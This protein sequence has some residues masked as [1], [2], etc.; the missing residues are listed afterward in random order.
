MNTLNTTDLRSKSS[1]KMHRMNRRDRITH[2]SQ[3]CYTHR[4]KKKTKQTK[5]EYHTKQSW[6][7]AAY[8][9]DLTNQLMGIAVKS[10]L[11]RY[12]NGT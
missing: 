3:K 12:Q 6:S 11:E 1:L 10:T 8:T 9:I 4:R 5:K 7:R 2:K